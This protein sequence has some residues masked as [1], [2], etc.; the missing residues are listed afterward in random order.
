[1]RL[2]D[3]VD[4]FE[5]WHF[6]SQTCG[7]GEI[8]EIDIEIF[9]LFLLFS[10]AAHIIR[11]GQGADVKFTPIRVLREH[12]I[13]IYGRVARYHDFRH[14]VKTQFRAISWNISS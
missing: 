4:G 1:M 14:G 12:C 8:T 3:I 9:V 2:L 7:G 11:A 5:K 13:I 10:I 6:N